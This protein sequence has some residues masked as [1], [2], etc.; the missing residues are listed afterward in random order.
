MKISFRSLFSQVITASYTHLHFCALRI[1]I[2]LYATFT[3]SVN[4]AY[5]HALK[6]NILQFTTESGLKSSLIVKKRFVAKFNGV[7][8]HSAQKTA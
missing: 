8:Q 1:F 7:W 4:L 6:Q 5:V 2:A 3:R